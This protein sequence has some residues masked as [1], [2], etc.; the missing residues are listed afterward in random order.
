MSTY[1]MAL[2]QAAIRALQDATADAEAFGE[3]YVRVRATRVQ[4]I[5][6][7]VERIEPERVFI[8]T[9]P[10]VRTAPEIEDARPIP[11]FGHG[12]RDRLQ[13]PMHVV[14]RTKSGRILTDAEIEEMALQA[15]Q[16][17]EVPTVVARFSG[18]APEN[19]GAALS[20]DILG[21]PKPTRWVCSPH[22]NVVIQDEPPTSTCKD[23]DR[24]SC[25]WTRLS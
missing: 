21:T 1:E 7:T 22:G 24:S 15:E 16:G 9:A 18:Y 19:T 5:I 12:L 10:T 11:E 14:Y 2:A 13:A 3:G 20:E 6:W 17:Y 4:E 23:A 25:L 8:R